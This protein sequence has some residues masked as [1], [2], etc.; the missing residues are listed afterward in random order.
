MRKQ[1]SSGSLAYERQGRRATAETTTEPWK[2]TAELFLIPGMTFYRIL[3]NER[4]Q[5]SAGPFRQSNYHQNK[6]G[7][8][9]RQNAY[10]AS[11]Q[12]METIE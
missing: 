1:S 2:S 3:L 8:R 10:I 5:S 12:R 11:G 9:I 6:G 7:I 4:E